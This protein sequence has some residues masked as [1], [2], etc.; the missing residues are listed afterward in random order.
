MEYTPRDEVEAAT[1]ERGS[2]EIASPEEEPETESVGGQETADNEE[3][4]E[5]PLPQVD[6][7]TQ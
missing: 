3:D 2:Q 5:E 6:E 1:V 7:Q 4:E